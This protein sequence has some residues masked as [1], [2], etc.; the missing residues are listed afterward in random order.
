MWL[1]NREVSFGETT[2]H[3]GLEVRSWI[4]AETHDI[5]IER[6]RTLT[7]NVANLLSLS[8][9]AA[10]ELADDIWCIDASE[11]APERQLTQH[12]AGVPTVVPAP[13][14]TDQGLLAVIAEQWSQSQRNSETALSIQR[15]LWHARTGLKNDDLV[16]Q[17]NHLWLG[18]ESLNSLLIRKY[19]LPTK[20]VARHCARCGNPMEVVGTSAGINHALVT[21][22]GQTREGAKRIRDIRKALYHGLPRIY[23]DRHDLPRV[24]PILRRALVFALADLTEVPEEFR[25]VLERRPYVLPRYLG[26]VTVSVTLKGLELHA[27]LATTEPPEIAI[28]VVPSEGST[29]PA[30][31]KHFG[32]LRV[33]VRNHKGEWANPTITWRGYTDPEKLASEIA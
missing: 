27:L 25:S 12:F 31:R 17:F 18:L 8:H 5:A 10:V 21:W 7:E 15:A 19:D 16:S 24:V 2:A 23:E 28:A 1:L 4:H 20:F 29:A 9:G 13:R 3:Q 6:T 26:E 22:A 30:A 14:E 11:A 33:G 32:S